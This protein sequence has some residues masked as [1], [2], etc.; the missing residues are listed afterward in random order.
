MGR[1]SGI[2]AT[3]EAI[4][5]LTDVE[6]GEQIAIT[7]RMITWLGPLPLKGAKKRLY[8]LETALAKR[9]AG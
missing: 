8:R 4:A 5:S 3:D 2:A 9:L 7:Q 6:L 1:R